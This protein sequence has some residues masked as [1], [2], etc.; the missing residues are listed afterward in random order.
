MTIGTINLEFEEAP[1]LRRPPR[2]IQIDPKE[3]KRTFV[4]DIIEN[5]NVEIVAV[6][7]LL[8]LRGDPKLPPPPPLSLVLEQ[9]YIDVTDSLFSK[10]RSVDDLIRAN[11][12]SATVLLYRAVRIERVSVSVGKDVVVPQFQVGL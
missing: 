6:R 3:K 12:E 1:L 10:V 9:I 8:R 5:M 7:L 4:D 11:K 2:I